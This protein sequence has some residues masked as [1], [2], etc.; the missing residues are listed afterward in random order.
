ML[1]SNSFELVKWSEKSNELLLRVRNVYSELGIN[2][3]SLP[4]DTF[5]G[6]K[7]ISL[8][9]AGQ[10]S[11]GKSTILKALTGIND[12]VVKEGIA[13]QETHEYDWMGMTV[14]DTPG[15]G[16]K[17]RPDHDEIAMKAISQADMLVYVV[18]HN[19]FDDQI[20]KEFRKLIITND[21]AKET[22]LVVNKMAEVGNN[23]ETRRIMTDALRNVTDPYLPE[24]LHICFVDA[25]SYVD[26]ISEEDEEIANDLIE[27][28]NYSGLVK[29]INEFVDERA[30]SVKLTTSLYRIL[31]SIQES[32]TQFLPSS[33]DDD[34]DSFEETQLRQK[35]ILSKTIKKIDADIKAKY[36]DAS[37]QIR[38]IGR[39]LANSL[40][41]YFE[42]CEVDDAF[43]NAQNK[44]DTISQQCSQNIEQAIENNLAE[45]NIEMEEFYSSPFT[46]NL[47]QRMKTKNYN[48]MPVIKKIVESEVLS[49]GGKVI[50]NNAGGTQAGLKGLVGF[51]GT[52]IHQ[53]VLDIGHF[54]GHSFKPWEAVKITKGINVA[55]RVLGVAGTVLS[56]FM[57]AKEDYD[58]EQRVKEQQ[59]ARGQIRGAYNSAAEELEKYFS[60]SLNNLIETKL[61]PRLEEIDSSI[62]SIRALRTSKSEKCN[63]LMQIDSDCRKLI[64]E[65]H[66]ATN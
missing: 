28:S 49:N 35:S 63:R 20:G 18:T 58:A 27:R 62:N 11:A 66:S 14:I 29:T 40:D 21:K 5:D 46:Q 43:K 32:V 25:E 34:I 8:V 54:F 17:L 56:V 31:D 24:S 38:D 1:A 2:P 19:L 45:Y 47:Y 33:G 22:I 10:Y 12:I 15:I 61:R 37:S 41:S 9:F 6:G 44:V 59:Q 16:T 55:G 7:K 4:E 26:S 36:R 65:I 23:I 53:I 50:I 60:K 42:Q 57:Q 52:N 64:G 30:L 39:D 48:D 13:T 51:K 3:E